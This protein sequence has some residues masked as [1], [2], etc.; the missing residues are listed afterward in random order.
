MR[1]A[2]ETWDSNKG[3]E[4]S[5]FPVYN[6]HLSSNLSAHNST[7]SLPVLLNTKTEDS[8]ANTL[9]GYT[10]THSQNKT[11]N[12]FQNA[13][14]S[15]TIDT[16]YTTNNTSPTNT[17]TKAGLL[18]KANGIIQEWRALYEESL[19]TQRGEKVNTVEG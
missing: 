12:S 3:W 15:S 6:S 19:T 16:N 8:N 10:Q 18:Q 9:Q 1:E 11:Q 4:N 7:N 5:T 2:F 14:N 13:H 17:V